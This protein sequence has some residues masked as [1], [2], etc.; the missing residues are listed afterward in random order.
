MHNSYLAIGNT[1]IPPAATAGIYPQIKS[2]ARV[3]GHSMT[4]GKRTHVRELHAKCLCEFPQNQ[5][6]DCAVVRRIRGGSSSK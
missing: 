4:I 1:G 6:V 3:G 5:P 2:H